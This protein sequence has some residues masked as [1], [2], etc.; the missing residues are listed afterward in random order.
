MAT[1]ESST[2]LSS[3]APR[4]YLD[5]AQSG[6]YFAGLLL[7]ALVAFWPSYLSKGLAASS[8]YT[9]LHA[10]AATLWILM[11]II[12]PMLIR[13][14][15]LELHRMLG[16]V[17]YG[18][19]TAVVLSVIFLAHS[20]IQGLEGSAYARQTFVLYLQTFLAFLF[21]ISYVLAILSRRTA[22]LHARFMICTSLTLID[23]IFIRLINWSDFQL[24]VSPFWFTFGL[25]DVIF[26]V[27]IFL[28][29][30]KT[31]GRRVFPIMLAVFAMG[32]FPA[33]F[34]LTDLPLWQSF[35]RWFSALPLT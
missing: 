31:S 34:R 1:I 19:A 2:L 29:R 10:A 17:S 14:R 9:H 3:P 26:L 33:L 32:Q 15:R 18:L 7:I 8:S 22:A 27:L 12:Q 5:F 35:A 21:A 13:T 11:L 28:E 24:P 30:N 20:R 6:P 23:P 25:T 4:K 16:R